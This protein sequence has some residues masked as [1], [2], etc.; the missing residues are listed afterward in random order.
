MSVEAYVARHGDHGW[1]LRELLRE[2]E[3][4][5]P[6]RV[7]LE[8][9]TFRG[10]SLRVWREH[11]DPELLVGVQDTDETTP[12]VA[13]ELG[14]ELVRGFSQQLETYLA[15]LGRLD[16]RP[17]DLLYVDGDHTYEA[18]SRDWELYSPLVRAGGLVVLHDAVIEDNPTVDVHRLYRELRVGR[19][20]K[21]LYGGRDSTG[22]A[23]V[24][25]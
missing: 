10:D 11:L 18:V 7:V 2:L 3:W 13:A 8:L 24:Y 17:V 21:L 23:L 9:G 16:G 12:E 5:A 15:V 25:V 1:E 19:R 14:C 20:T 6:M 4:L 22:A